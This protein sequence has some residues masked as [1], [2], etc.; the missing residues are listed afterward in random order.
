MISKF[1]GLV[2]FLL[3]LPVTALAQESYMIGYAGFAG[4]QVSMWAVKDLGLLKKYGLEG[5]VVMVPGTSR[6]VQALVSDSIQFA[7]LDAAG[8]I[9]AIMGGAEFVLVGASLNKFPFSFVT[10]KEIRK[11]ADLVGKKIGI[12]G[13]GGA[14]DF[15][16]TLLLKEWK[17]PRESVTVL[18]AGGGANRLVALSANAL[19]ATV[20]SY[21]EL[22]EALR[23]GMNEMSNLSELKSAEY[24]MAAVGVRRAFLEQKRDTVKRFMKA[25]AEATYEFMNNKE[26]GISVYKK[27]LKQD[28]PKVLE[29]TYQYFASR[30]SFP[31]RV[32]ESGLRSTVEMIAKGNSKLESKLDKYVDDSI[33]DELEKEGFFKKVAGK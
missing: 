29:D 13:F 15:A 16:V 11:P 21:P 12:V 23:L 30:F 32:S 9:R 25:Y 17:I 5:E 10:R 20:L 19:D 7:H 3:V 4:F 28:N 31:T 1:M 22:G 18:Q 33:M 6:Q 27:R 8:S 26:K 2:L 14:N 24:P